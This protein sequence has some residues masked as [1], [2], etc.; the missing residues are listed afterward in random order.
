VYVNQKNADVIRS[1]INFLLITIDDAFDLQL[2]Y[3]ILKIYKILKIHEQVIDELLERAIRHVDYNT[4]IYAELAQLT[5]GF[6]RFYFFSAFN[7]VSADTVEPVLCLKG[8]PV[9]K[10]AFVYNTFYLADNAEDEWGDALIYRGYVLECS[11]SIDVFTRIRA[12]DGDINDC[13]AGIRRIHPFYVPQLVQL[14]RVERCFDAVA[15]KI[16]ELV[17]NDDY[18]SMLVY[19]NVRANFRGSERIGGLLEKICTNFKDTVRFVD[20]MTEISL[21]MMKYRHLDRFDKKKMLDELL[22]EVVIGRNVVLPLHGCRVLGILRNSSR[23]LQSHAKVPFMATFIVERNGVRTNADLIF[24]AGDDCRQDQLAL[25]LI[26]MFLNIFKE[27]NL[28][29]FVYPYTVISTDYECGLIEVITDAISRD[30]MGRE[31]INNLSEYFSLK[32]GFKEGT[33]YKK[34]HRRFILSFVGYSLVTYFLNVKDRHNG[35]IMINGRGEMIHI[36]FGFMFDISPGGLN[37]EVPLK[38]TQ[39][40]VE[41]LDD[42]MDEYVSLMIQGF[43]ALRRRSKDIVLMAASF[44]N[45]QLPCFT[46]NAI[47]NLIARFKFHLS[48]AELKVY[49]RT[50]IY[51]SVRKFR[52]YIYDKFQAL[53]NDIS[54]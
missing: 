21:K 29:I 13:L 10:R 36:D 11:E 28:P 6:Y 41:L 46:E 1:A 50:M 37:L 49:I 33:A 52:T 45:S 51:T 31:K 16:L 43:F 20:D 26:Q 5:D 34:A 8:V 18:L 19:F 30:Q 48:D 47:D 2:L 23:V 32:F 12:F 15:R 14:L 9:N 35:N 7:C 17:R 25:Q 38:I 53:T 40:I 27:S 44:E 54:F 22:N 39:E 24:K 3:V 4:G 42:H